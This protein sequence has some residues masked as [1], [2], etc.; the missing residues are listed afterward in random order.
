[1][2]GNRWQF[3]LPVRTQSHHHQTLGPKDEFSLKRNEGLG[4]LPIIGGNKIKLR[5][6][7]S[8]MKT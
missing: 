7:S 3:S 5:E 1:L 6:N 8:Q 2:A 4:M